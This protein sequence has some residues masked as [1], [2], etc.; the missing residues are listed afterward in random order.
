[1]IHTNLSAWTLLSCVING[2]SCELTMT[3]LEE[4]SKPVFKRAV[5]VEPE[6]M[7]LGDW[8]ILSKQDARWCLSWNRYLLFSRVFGRF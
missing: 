1:M 3:D 7:V 6:E 4:G 5:N 2:L 8:G